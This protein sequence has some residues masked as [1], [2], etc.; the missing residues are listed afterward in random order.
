MKRMILGLSAFAASVALA[1]PTVKNVTM[2]QGTDRLVTITYDLED[3]D[4]IITLSVE[5]NG[6]PLAEGEV[7]CL[8]GDVSKVVKAGTGKTI[9]WRA[10]QSWPNHKVENAR[11]RVTAWSKNYPPLY[12]V[13]DLTKGSAA[14]TANPWPVT[15]YTSREAIPDGEKHERYKTTHLLMRRV[16]PTS[17]L[18]FT[19]GA[20]PNETGYIAEREIRHTVH[21]TKPYYLGVYELTQGQGYYMFDDSTTTPLLPKFGGRW[22]LMHGNCSVWPWSAESDDGQMATATYA[23]WLRKMR[24]RSGFLFDLPTEA[25]WEYACR[26]GTTGTLN[27]GTFSLENTK[28]D[29]HLKKLGLYAGNK[30]DLTGPTEVGSYEPNAWG[31]YDMHGNVMEWCFD[32]AYCFTAAEATDP[33]RGAGAAIN[34]YNR[35]LRGGGWNSDAENCRSGCRRTHCYTDSASLNSFGGNQVGVRLMMQSVVP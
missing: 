11:A 16:D 17:D 20:D 27:D 25:Q 14:T 21:L 18:G 9:T 33:T 24:E 5:T 12:A 6:V 13:F 19:M 1:A 3:E 22:A 4:A 26:A 30:G 34:Q 8:F 2:T 28:T 15:F 31:F 32:A 23:T 35:V 29:S 10:C 7:S